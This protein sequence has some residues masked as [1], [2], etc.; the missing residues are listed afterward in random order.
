MLREDG[1]AAR[2]AGHRYS[3]HQR[4][5]GRISDQLIGEVVDAEPQA[6]ALSANEKNI[7]DHDNS[8]EWI[9]AEGSLEQ[10]VA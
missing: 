6:A 2:V 7:F 10:K 3:S 8:A 1:V 9:D 5:P 4:P